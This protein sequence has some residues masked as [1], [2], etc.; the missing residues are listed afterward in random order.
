VINIDRHDTL[1]WKIVDVRV[2]RASTTLF[3]R[4]LQKSLM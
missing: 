3:I 1:L 2:R 4:L